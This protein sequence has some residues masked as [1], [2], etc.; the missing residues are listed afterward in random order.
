MRFVR[1]RSISC[2]L[3]TSIECTKWYNETRHFKL[4]CDPNGIGRMPLRTRTCYRVIESAR[5]SSWC[6]M[7]VACRRWAFD[8]LPPHST[9]THTD[10]PKQIETISQIPLHLNYE[11]MI[12]L[13]F[14]YFPPFDG[15]C[16]RAR[17]LSERRFSKATHNLLM[18][19]FSGWIPCVMLLCIMRLKFH[20]RRSTHRSHS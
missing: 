17:V 3:H 6:S 7:L 9:H 10:E 5:I 20:V 11:F 15:M 1:M 4:N 19:L 12:E 2:C 18:S 14:S 13:R 16:S 8:C